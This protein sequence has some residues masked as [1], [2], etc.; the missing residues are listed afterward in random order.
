MSY[1]NGSDRLASAA[2]T[3]QY[4]TAEDRV[5]YIPDGMDGRFIPGLK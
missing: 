4:Y 2:D 3:F 1:L 5:W